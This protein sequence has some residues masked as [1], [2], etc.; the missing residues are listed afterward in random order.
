MNNANAM[1]HDWED[2]GRRDAA[3][4]LVV[5]LNYLSIEAARNGFSGT[6][7]LI[8]TAARSL[9]AGDAPDNAAN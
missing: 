3:E 6:S 8:D 2:G 5:A 9:T 7:R 4:D 1:K